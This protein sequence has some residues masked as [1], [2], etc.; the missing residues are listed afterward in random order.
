MHLRASHVR[1][2]SEHPFREPRIKMNLA[3]RG[4][5][6]RYSILESAVTDSRNADSLSHRGVELLAAHNPQRLR[7]PS[8]PPLPLIR[9]TLRRITASSVHCAMQA[10]R[11]SRSHGMALSVL[12]P[13]DRLRTRRSPSP[14]STPATSRRQRR[15]PVA[16]ASLSGN[17]NSSFRK[18]S[19]WQ[20]GLAHV[21]RRHTPL[22]ACA[23]CMMCS[24]IPSAHILVAR[25]HRV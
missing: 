10:S 11:T 20:R 4:P 9:H 7:K 24:R 18:T 14:C 21:N 12:T 16:R 5:F 8:A 19:L 6:F 2:V 23:A 25:R 13:D 15:Q 17:S 1:R 3:E 22:S